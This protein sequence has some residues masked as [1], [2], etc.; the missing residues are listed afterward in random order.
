MDNLEELHLRMRVSN[1]EARLELHEIEIAALSKEIASRLTSASRR[2]EAKE[3]REVQQAEWRQI[4][5]KLDELYR[6]HPR[7]ARMG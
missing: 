6:S 4:K 5:A 1:L 2:E 3:L 7:F